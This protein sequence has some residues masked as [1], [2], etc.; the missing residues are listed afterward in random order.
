M[1][2]RTVQDWWDVLDTNWSPL[3][4]LFNKF[5]PDFYEPIDIDGELLPD[6]L[7]DKIIRLKDERDP[8]LAM[9][10][11][12]A[13]KNAPSLAVSKLKGWKTLCDLKAFESWS[14]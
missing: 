7:L 11:H 10:V 13:W 4:V 6:M 2:I 1:M 8:R 3:L 12:A 14:L 9:Y 5:L